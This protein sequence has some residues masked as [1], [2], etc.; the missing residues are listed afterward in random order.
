[1]LRKKRGFTII[2]VLTVCFIVAILAAILVPNLRRAIVKTEAVGCKSNLKNLATAITLYANDNDH[3]YPPDLTKI[4]PYNFARM[5]TCQSTSTDTYTT[6]YSVST[7]Y[8]SFTLVCKGTNHSKY[9]YGADEPYY[10]SSEGLMPV[11]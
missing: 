7:D 11:F 10:S 1:M 6:G 5:P 9:G 2:E 3:M 8:R 4:I